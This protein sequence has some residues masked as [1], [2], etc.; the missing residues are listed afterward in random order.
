MMLIFPHPQCLGAFFSEPLNSQCQHK[1]I[2][3]PLN[4]VNYWNNFKPFHALNASFTVTYTHTH[5]TN[6]EQQQ[7][8]HC[9]VS[10]FVFFVRVWILFGELFICNL[11]LLNVNSKPIKLKFNQSKGHRPIQIKFSLV[12]SRFFFILF[13][14]NSKEPQVAHYYKPVILWIITNK[15]MTCVVIVN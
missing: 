1:Y 10:W 8:S 9:T 12:R 3:S 14:F 2:Y 7:K 15:R 13:S 5:M 4:L 11:R 6:W